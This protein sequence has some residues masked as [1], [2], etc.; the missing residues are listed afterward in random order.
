M[1]DI[2]RKNC[3]KELF[4]KVR[5]LK[6]SWWSA[7]DDLF[8][9]FLRINLSVF[10]FLFTFL[11]ECFNITHNVAC[12]PRE[13]LNGLVTI[14]LVYFFTK[15]AIVDGSL[16][17]RFKVKVI[18]IWCDRVEDD[19]KAYKISI[20]KMYDSGFEKIESLLIR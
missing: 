5:P 12:I 18:S 19:S 7:R 2:W 17:V 8:L 3:Q 11:K 9:H 14:A 20:W 16:Y 10:I 1:A 15:K 13:G 4:E 6:V